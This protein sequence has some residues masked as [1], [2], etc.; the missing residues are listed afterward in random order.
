M[1]DQSTV[2]GLTFA[3]SGADLVVSWASTAADGTTFQVYLGR[4]LSWW[5]AS[6]SAR[7]PWPQAAVHVDVGAVVD[8]E[9][10]TDFSAS[11]PATPS[12]RCNLTWLGGTFLGAVAGFRVFGPPGPGQAV[13]YAKPVAVLPAYHGV[14]TDGYDLGGYD[15]GGWGESASSYS[16]TSDPLAPGSWT[17]AVAPYDGAGN[18]SGSP[19]TQ[20]VTIASPPRPP[21]ANATGRRLSY[22]YNAASGVATL[23]WLPSPA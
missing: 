8:G 5:G 15:Q 6:T 16:W 7:F 1:F 14:V 19:S 17:F 13:S 9:G 20:T 10:P 2:S 12:D 23:G 22:T 4:R 11:L 21:A 18:L 3:R